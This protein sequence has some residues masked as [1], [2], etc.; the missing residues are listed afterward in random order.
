[1]ST[2]GP[3]DLR[4]EYLSPHAVKLDPHNP[5]R[6]TDLQI[7]Q[8]ARS[9][10]TFGF[11]VPVVIDG[12]NTVRAGHGRVLAAR[13]MALQGIPVIRLIHLTEAQAR[14]FGIA[15]N[16]LTDNSSW[17]DQLLGEVFRDLTMVDLD[18]T[19]EATG[20]SMGEIDLRIE[21]LSTTA[22]IEAEPAEDR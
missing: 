9:V 15:D 19:L 20:F 13:K 2:S 5:R 7:A 1:M 22:T 12:T 18:F 10:Q 4:I 21:G 14:A 8:I 16:K 3:P 6:H 11:N 17:D